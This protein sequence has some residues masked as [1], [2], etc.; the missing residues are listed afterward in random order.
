MNTIHKQAS[1]LLKRQSEIQDID[2]LNDARKEAV[3]HVLT[4]VLDADGF[5]ILIASTKDGR[6]DGLALA[7]GAIS[8]MK[9]LEE[10]LRAVERVAG[11]FGVE[12]ELK[13]KRCLCPECRTE[14]GKRTLQ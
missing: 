7:G 2:P 6:T 13:V 4:R 9:T 3:S 1:R 12:L 8:P 10:L 5:T 11:G 14:Q